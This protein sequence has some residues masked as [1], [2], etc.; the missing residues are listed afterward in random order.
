MKLF[1]GKNVYKKKYRIFFSHKRIIL[2]YWPGV[3]S[4]LDKC[5]PSFAVERWKT[6]NTVKTLKSILKQ[7]KK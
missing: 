5:L 3:L 6:V 2:A 7:K 1:L 4:F